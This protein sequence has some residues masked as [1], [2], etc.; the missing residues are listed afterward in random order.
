MAG[1]E[2]AR[3][4]AELVW[5]KRPKR[6]VECGTGIGYSGLWIARDL[7]ASGLSGADPS[8]FSWRHRLV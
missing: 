4:L 6:V 3:R 1:P 8:T 7:K 5:Q 2:K